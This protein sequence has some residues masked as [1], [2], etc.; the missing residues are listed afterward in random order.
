M[1][2]HL[3]NDILYLIYKYIPTRD[4]L[5]MYFILKP[6]E[7]RISPLHKSM[8]SIPLTLY[9]RF[10][11][12]HASSVLNTLI[13]YNKLSSPTKYSTM[14]QRPY[15]LPLD[16]TDYEDNTT[17]VHSIKEIFIRILRDTFT[18]YSNVYHIDNKGCHRKIENHILSL[19]VF[20]HLQEKKSNCEI[21]RKN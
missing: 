1:W 16:L 15:Q 2:H 5:R 17:D 9:T 8:H 7:E 18:Y 10:I 20:C 4:R 3:P 19:L 6:V 14:Q 21:D 12:K 11:R 13:M